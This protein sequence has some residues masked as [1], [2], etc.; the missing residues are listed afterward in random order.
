MGCSTKQE[1]DWTYEAFSVRVMYRLGCF[2][3]SFRYELGGILMND[4][5]EHSGREPAIREG[6]RIPTIIVAYHFFPSRE[7]GARRMSALAQYLTAQGRAVAVISAFAGLGSFAAEDSGTATL[8][9]Y[10]L[11]RVPER[12]SIIDSFLVNA[13]KWLRSGVSVL[14]RAKRGT[15]VESDSAEGNR[16][17]TRSGLHRAIFTVLRAID[18]K[19]GWSM[20]AGLRLRSVAARHS[21]SV[22]VVSAPP[23]SPLFAIVFTA[24]KLK[25]P[26][27]VDLRDPITDI[28]EANDE[29]SRSR[30]WAARRF[31]ERYVIAH[32]DAIVTT[33]PG[34][35]DR[36][37]SKYP[38][39]SA[40]ILC[41][42][43]GFDGEMT[44]ARN[45]TGNQLTMV[46]AGELY[47]NR[48]PFPFLEAVDRLLNHSGV[49]EARIRV[50]FA[51]QCEFYGGISVR[52]WSSPRPCGRVLTIHPPL[53]ATRLKR[54]YEDA[55]LLLNFAEGQ[56]IQVPAKTFELLS[57][58]R[59]VLVACEPYSDT[60]RI[61]AG[62]DG[63]FGVRL[64]ETAQLDDLLRS[65]YQRH[66]VEGRMSP[67]TRE[68]V[69]RYSRAIQNE[70]YRTVIDRVGLRLTPFAVDGG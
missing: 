11:E 43:N 1:H 9:A 67:P 41:I 48:N 57:L 8:A 58:G 60:S 49:D 65:F 34:L 10:D 40:R 33:T 17:Q 62:I 21:A 32:A 50:V 26:V 46:F 28:G 6:A 38:A 36:L 15:P 63:V 54:L 19:K 68:S 12:K 42:F 66:V 16:R 13:K 29:R 20:R 55:T 59:E 18:D 45:D 4:S 2:G 69:L 39:A 52:A 30:P 27:V 24:R 51:G 35:R 22:I 7:V 14:Q 3:R 5:V 64:S 70:H 47:L 31:V 23:V 56:P 53:D 25:L 61:I 37:R 44:A